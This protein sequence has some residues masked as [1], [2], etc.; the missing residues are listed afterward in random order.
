MK[1]LFLIPLSIATLFAAGCSTSSQTSPFPAAAESPAP[2]KAMTTAFEGSWKGNDVTPGHEG[3]ASLT[4][5]GNV[6]DFHG[7]DADDWLKGT[8]TLHEDTNPRQFVGVVTDCASPD[9]VGKK[10]RAIYKI[11]DGT[12]TIAG[13]GLDDPNFPASFD[14]PGTR[15]LVFKHSQ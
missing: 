7:V 14:A 15:L 4:V 10:A 1:K 12:L 3:T 2:P 9:N 8:F 6:L 11:E 13:A 5:T